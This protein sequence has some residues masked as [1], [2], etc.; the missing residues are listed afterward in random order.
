MSRGC[1]GKRYN[2][3]D[4]FAVLHN[5]GLH[6]DSVVSVTVVTMVGGVGVSIQVSARDI[7]CH[8][9]F[10]AS[11]HCEPVVWFSLQQTQED[12]SAV[13]IIESVLHK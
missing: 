9:D 5:S 7:H 1:G 8:W 4:S 13:K 6:S 3:C 2:L 10:M 12:S 11:D